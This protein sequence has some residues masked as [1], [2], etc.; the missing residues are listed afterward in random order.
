[1]DKGV[2]SHGIRL[3]NVLLTNALFLIESAALCHGKRKRAPWKIKFYC[4]LLT[5]RGAG[6]RV[7]MPSSKNRSSLNRSPCVQVLF[8]NRTNPPPTTSHDEREL[9]LRG[10]PDTRPTPFYF[11]ISPYLL[12]FPFLRFSVFFC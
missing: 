9:S 12:F 8:P 5:D 3:F 1:M 4:F 11:S 7:R 2:S 10:A 6:A